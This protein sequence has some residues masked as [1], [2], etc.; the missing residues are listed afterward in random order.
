MIIFK[1][2]GKQCDLLFSCTWRISFSKGQPGSDPCPAF[3][4][5]LQQWTENKAMNE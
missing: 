1:F 5:S 2:C 3:Y 4:E